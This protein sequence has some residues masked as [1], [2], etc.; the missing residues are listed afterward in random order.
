[1]YRRRRYHVGFIAT[2]NGLLPRFYYNEYQ[3]GVYFYLFPDLSRFY[4]GFLNER[5]ISVLY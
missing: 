2:A 1:M 4:P 5:R 3:A